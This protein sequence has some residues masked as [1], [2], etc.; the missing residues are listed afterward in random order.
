MAESDDDE[1]KPW[2]P[3][4]VSDFLGLPA[5]LAQELKQLA[6]DM[7]WSEDDKP[8]IKMKK[9]T[10]AQIMAHAE[11][12]ADGKKKKKKKSEVVTADG[13]RK[14]PVISW[15][16]AVEYSFNTWSEFPDRLHEVAGGSG[17]GRT[18]PKL[19]TGGALFRGN[20]K[21]K[22]FFDTT[23]CKIASCTLTADDKVKI[24]V[25]EYEAD[26]ETLA[27]DDDDDF[28]KPEK[29][30]EEVAAEA[31]AEEE[32]A[33]A[34]AAAAEAAAAARP[35]KRKDG[36]RPKKEYAP[37]KKKPKAATQEQPATVEVTYT[38]PAPGSTR[39]KRAA[40]KK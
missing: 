18:A 40:A 7:N 6:S 32:A 3:L 24:K 22:V 23:E 13:N 33:A 26:D 12:Q 31:A 9:A 15:A 14:T 25:G 20:A 27:D 19:K 39:P 16:K 2:A 36:G 38:A 8:Y 17:W 34:A 35:S 30:D 21:T 11:E 5:R 10:E 1:T 4:P 28:P 37:R 29:T